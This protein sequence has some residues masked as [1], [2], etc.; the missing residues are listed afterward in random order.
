[1]DYK[2]SPNHENVRRVI[3]SLEKLGVELN[4]MDSFPTIAVTFTD[5]TP[6]GAEVSY[7][8]GMGEDSTDIIVTVRDV[9]GFEDAS[10]KEGVKFLN[11]FNKI[12]SDAFVC[13]GTLFIEDEHA[14]LRYYIDKNDYALQANLDECIRRIQP[15][16]YAIEKVVRNE[17]PFDDLVL[18]NEAPFPSGGSS[19]SAPS[20]SGVP[21][22]EAP[23]KKGLLGKL[24]S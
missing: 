12:Q 6:S 13:S 21:E 1:M 10:L 2:T 22:A 8:V 3:G 24:F 23:K 9:P 11:E 14:E 16:V 18:K 20:S 17:A 15:Y 4:I 19:D 5:A 7:G